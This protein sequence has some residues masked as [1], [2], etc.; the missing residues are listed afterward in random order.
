MFEAISFC[1]Q[2]KVNV[3]APIDIGALVECMLFYEKTTVIA[4]PA[5]LAQLIKYFGVERLLVLINEGLLKIIYTESF[6]GIIT[7]T[8]GNVQYHDAIEGSSPQHTYQ[9][10]LR[11]ICIDVTGRSGKGRRLAQK[12]QDKIHVTKHDHIILEGAR[13]S[14]LDQEYIGTAA[15][16]VIAEWVP[17]I[18]NASGIS[19]HTDRTAEGIRVDTNLNFSALNAQY[20]KRISPTHSS[21]TSASILAH[22]LDVEKE[23]YF[24]SSNLSELA[25]SSLSAKL[26]EAKIDYILARTTKSREALSNFT[27]FLFKDAKAIREAVNSGHV[28][29]DDLLAVLQNS[30]HFKKWIVNVRPEA[31]LIQSYYEEVTKKTIIDRLP[32]KSMRWALFTGL[33]LT[34][35]AI[36]TGGIGTLAGV[37]LGA[38]DTFYIDKLISGWKPNQ[39]IEDDIRKLIDKNT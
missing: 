21:I 3:K 24:S 16:I 37:A 19:F 12:I 31:N 2:D 39:F 20:H 32:G 35:D 11:K 26:A 15:K 9:D 13:K 1:A 22:I 10:E 33:G 28:D 34:A 29:L 30:K 18:R 6:V 38:L 5:I 14:I 4:N 23:L 25:S 27:E 36:A 7:N 17:E 8:K